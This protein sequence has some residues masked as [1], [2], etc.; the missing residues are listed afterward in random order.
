MV[1]QIGGRETIAER[2]RVKGTLRRAG[3]FYNLKQNKLETNNK[4]IETRI[5]FVGLAQIEAKIKCRKK[6]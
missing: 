3:I 1:K 5:F 4:S 6:N 2:E